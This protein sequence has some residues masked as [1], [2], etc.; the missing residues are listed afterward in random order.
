MAAVKPVGR[1]DTFVIRMALARSKG[2]P[3]SLKFRFY[4]GKRNNAADAQSQTDRLA[5]MAEWRTVSSIR[6]LTRH[7]VQMLQTLALGP[8]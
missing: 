3:A 8:G 5:V 1:I 2:D 4:R 7:H 6:F